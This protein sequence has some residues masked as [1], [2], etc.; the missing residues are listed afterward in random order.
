M[1]AME[2]K[3]VE[4]DG[5]T[6]RI[7]IY[8]DSDA[9]CPSEWEGWRLVSFSHRHRSYEPPERYCKG[10][11]TFGGPIPAHIGLSRKLATGTA[12]W[13]SYYEHGLC[14]WS[15]MGEGS[16]CRWDST[17]LAGILLWERPPPELP[18]GYA[19]READ[20]RR[21]LD[22]YTAWANGEVYGYDIERLS[23]CECCGSQL[24]EPVDSCFGIYG[25][26][27]CL[28]EAEAILQPSTKE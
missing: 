10:L 5:H 12:F 15:L 18:A 2:T 4:H 14:R 16:Q 19:K 1:K 26:G 6:F 24:A 3:T 28:S 17:R 22:T 21:F 11:D 25:L 20:A 7:S 23:T 9:E 27:T 13:L 8:P